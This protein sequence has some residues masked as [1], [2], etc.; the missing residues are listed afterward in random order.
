M[1]KCTNGAMGES[2]KGRKLV[3][4]LRF[5]ILSIRGCVDG[6][7]RGSVHLCIAHVLRSPALLHFSVSA[8]ALWFPAWRSDEESDPDCSA[9]ARRGG[10]GPGAAVADECRGRDL[11]PR[12]P[13][14]RRRRG[15][16]E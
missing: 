9:A 7:I 8:F 13:E 4:F 10:T 3:G 11:R 12:A 15:A 16:Q 6:W 5:C 1:H 2:G 14:R